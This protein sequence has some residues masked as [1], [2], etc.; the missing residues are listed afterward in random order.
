LD[1]AENV[2]ISGD[3]A[4][5]ASVADDSLTI[6]DISDPTDPVLKSEVYDGDGEFSELDGAR[7]V[8]VSGNYAYVAAYIDDAFTIM[9]ITDP[10]DPVLKSEVSDG[11]GEFTKLN[12]ARSVYVSGNYA[13]VASS[14]DD[15]L[16]IM[17]IT[18]PTD[19]VLKSEVFDG[20]GE[21][22]KLNGAR[23]VY[24]SGNYAYVA[25]I[26]DDSL[27]IMDITD[28][29]DP[30][31][32]SEVYDGDG[33]FSELDGAR[34]VYVSG[35]YAYVAA[36]IDDAFTIMDITDPTDPVLKS[37]VYNGDGEF[38]KL[39]SPRDVYV[40]GN[41]AY[42]ASSGNNSLTI[43]DITDPTDPVLKSEVSDGDGE[44][45]RL[46]G[47][48]SVYVLGDYAYVVSSIDD[49]LTIMNIAGGRHT[50]DVAS[51]QTATYLD[52]QD[53]QTLTS[54]I[55]CSCGTCTNSGN[56]DDVETTPFWVFA[57][58]VLTQNDFRFY[59]DSDTNDVSDPWGN[60]D[61]AENESTDV[62]PTSD[63][64]LESGDEIRVRANV[65][66]SCAL[67]G[68]QV[69][70]KLQYAEGPS[71]YRATS[72]TD[73]GAGGGGSIWRYATSSVT[74]GAEITSTVLTDTDVAGRYVKSAAPG[75]NPN[76]LTAGQDMEWDFHVEN[77]GATAAASYCYRAVQS[78]DTVLDTY[79]N[80]PRL[81][82]LPSTDK[83]MRH[84]NVFVG[85]QEKGFTWVD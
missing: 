31:L 51:A 19:P 54:N 12:G 74:D 52:V 49:S 66:S 80:Y 44:F 26:S 27:T 23:S 35:N 40:S 7:S 38:S 18:D 70:L 81:E 36:Y 77:N 67:A 20:D 21:F 22:T 69:E 25:S 11:D 15:S 29:T 43:M 9:D 57:S 3:Y 10:T 71:C 14:D 58:N 47:A 1:G 13:Y 76:S 16:T 62:V 78:D 59:A 41:Y 73:V 55:T 85:G 82:T 48:H 39:N 2:F 84:G 5:I 33:E 79:T 50:W 37:E 72:W 65:T 61:L 34:S 68:A 28:P 6:M 83:I 30:V 24:V 46:E 17:D 56:N 4:Y 32:K 63:G 53:S 75:T 42:V 8:Y 64:A 45:S 60:P